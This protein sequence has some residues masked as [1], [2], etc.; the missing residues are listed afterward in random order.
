MDRAPPLLFPAIP[1]IVARLAVATS[2]GKKSPVGASL[3]FS[4]SRISPGSTRA[5]RAS[6]SISSTRFRWRDVSTTTARPI[7]CPHWEVPAPRGR[8]GTP[9][10]RAMAMTASMSSSV[11]GS[12]THSGSI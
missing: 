2:T 4:W 11:R 9:S 5:V 7:A 8:T 10:S 12:T 1:P 3:R 6:R